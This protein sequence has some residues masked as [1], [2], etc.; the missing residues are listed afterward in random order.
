MSAGVPKLAFFLTFAALGCY[1]LLGARLLVAA[2]IPYDEEGGSPFLKLHPGTYVAAIAC[3]LR[4]CAGLRPLCVCWRLAARDRGL[5]AAGAAILFCVLYEA[6]LS[7]AGGLVMLLDSFLPACLVGIS[8]ADMTPEQASRLTGYLRLLVLLNAAIALGEM[9][10]HAHLVP[11]D[12]PSA[13]PRAE[14]RPAALYDHPLTGAA[15][16]M[17]GVLLAPPPR[18]GAPWRV[19][20]QCVLIAALISFGGRAAIAM[21]CVA[22]TVQ[23]GWKAGRYIL[24]RRLRPID[25]RMPSL[26]AFA[27]I[28][29]CWLFSTSG[30]AER[31]E[32]HSYWDPSAETR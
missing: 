30:M 22:L 17:I 16:T 9:A 20:W 18:L 13:S 19:V 29:I 12:D 25:F 31:L 26:C 5:A 11:S 3:A 6:T 15:A 10:A 14:F 2:G 21:T 27:A 8:L 7:G 4:L 28:P 32:T 24:A 1:F 23:C